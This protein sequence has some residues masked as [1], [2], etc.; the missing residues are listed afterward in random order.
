MIYGF[1]PMNIFCMC[2]ECFNV[3]CSNEV[4]DLEQCIDFHIGSRAHVLIVGP[5]LGK[6]LPNWKYEIRNFL[7]TPSF[8]AICTGC[9]IA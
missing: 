8:V 5:A 3:S 4:F 2:L 7:E 9:K 1:V 6:E